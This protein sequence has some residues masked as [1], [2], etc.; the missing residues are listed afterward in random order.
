MLLADIMM[1]LMT[2]GLLVG[3]FFIFDT[4]ILGG[5]F[6]RKLKHMAE[7]KFESSCTQD[8][9]QGRNCKCVK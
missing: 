5:V 8:C 9:N 7:T 3:M 1:T 6:S 2:L 4:V